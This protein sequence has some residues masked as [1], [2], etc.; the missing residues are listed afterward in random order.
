[1]SDPT[2]SA[3]ALALAEEASFDFA[4]G[5]EAGAL[6]K[7]AAAVAAP[8]PESKLAFADVQ[9]HGAPPKAG[10]EMGGAGHG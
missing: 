3:R 10:L 7:L 8:F 9:D 2:P 5:D 1:M 4:I 6:A